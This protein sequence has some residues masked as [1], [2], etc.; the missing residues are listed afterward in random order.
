MATRQA[1]LRAIFSYVNDLGETPEFEVDEVFKL[2]GFNNVSVTRRVLANGDDSTSFALLGSTLCALVVLSVDHPFG[3]EL[4][5]GETQLTNGKV[6]V[7]WGDDDDEAAI[8]NSSILLTG[9]GSNDSN[10]II[11]QVEATT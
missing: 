11:F 7:W 3:L 2:Q 8:P 9:N 10:L 5:T 4:A 6:F 1:T